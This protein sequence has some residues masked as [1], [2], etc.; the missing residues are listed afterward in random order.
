MVTL[1][2]LIALRARWWRL[3]PTGRV[4]FVDQQILMLNRMEIKLPIFL[5]VIPYV[6]LV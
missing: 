3:S 4:F 1:A 6:V 5:G 2:M